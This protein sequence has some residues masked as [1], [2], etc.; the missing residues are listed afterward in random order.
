MAKAG[1]TLIEVVVTMLI[2]GIMASIAGLG[3]LSGVRG[4]VFAKNNSAI[5]EKAQLAMSRMNRSFLEILDISAIGTS[6][7][8][9]TYNRLIDGESVQ[10]TLYVSTS[11]NTIKI[12]AGGNPSGGDTLIDN[13][14]SL[15][16]IYKYGTSAW[17]V[18]DDFDRLSTIEVNLVLTRPDGGSNVTFASVI[19]PRNNANRGGSTSTAVPPSTTSCFVATAAFG[20]P[21]HP[22]VIALKDFRDRCLITWPGGK[23]VVRAYYK[24]GPYMAELIRGHYWACVL[25]QIFLLPIAGTALL[26]IYIPQILPLIILL[27]FTITVLISKLVRN[28]K[29]FFRPSGQK[30]SILLGLI[31]TIV[32][33]AVL[34]AALVSITSSSSISQISGIASTRAYYLAE[35]GMRYAGSEFRNA[36][37]ETAK[38]DKLT[39]LHN[40]NYNFSGGDG[41]FHLE[42]YPFYFKTVG[43]TNGNTLNAKFPGGVPSDMTIPP[44]NGYLKIGSDSSPRQYSSRSLSGS[45]ITFTMY[46][47][48]SAAADTNVLP[49]GVASANPSLMMGGSVTLLSGHTLFPPVNGTFTIGTASSTTGATTT[50]YSYKRRNNNVLE[51]VRLSQSP[52]TSFNVAVPANA[53]ITSMKFVNLQSRGTYAKGTSMEASRTISYSIPIGWISA[54]GPSTEKAKFQDTF[55]NASD[56]SNYWFTGVGSFQVDGGVLKVT[57]SGSEL[58]HNGGFLGWWDSYYRTSLLTL[59][60]AAAGVDL[61]QSW[62]SSGYLLSYDAQV[63]IKNDYTGLFYSCMAG[64]I[65]RV[66]TTGQSYGVSFLRP[67]S[68]D[69]I[70]GSGFFYPSSMSNTPMIV[71][72]QA[73]IV[74][75][76]DDVPVFDVKWLAYKSLNGT[77]SGV[78]NSSKKLIPWSTLLVRVIEAVSMEFSQGSDEIKY[79]DTITG[80]I[81]GATAFVNG[82]PILDDN[83]SWG[84]NATGWLTVSSTSGNFQSSG[85]DLKV[86]GIVKAHYT[87]NN[88]TKD[89][90]IRVYYGTNA[91][92]GS[93]VN[94]VSITDNNRL[95]HPVVTGANE[96]KWP[97]DNLADLNATTNDFFT[98]VQ[99]DAVNTGAGGDIVRLGGSSSNEANAII[100]TNLLV[101]P[102]TGTFNRSEVGLD[103]WGTSNTSTQFDDFGLQ[104]P[105]PGQTQGFLPGIQQ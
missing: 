20:N 56:L 93:V 72:W 104:A 32:I 57:S 10:E 90:Y 43:V 55:S 101:T 96:V 29:T 16:L 38:D 22:V 17:V 14:N 54:S 61:N 53:Y 81:S 69:S 85:E 75:Y 13:V 30:G 78:F 65:F 11:D 99:W 100:R 98:L 64:L 59:N 42:I 62:M 84:S 51:G 46:D 89:N 5:S 95:A 71:L 91:S 44:A 9:V 79:G 66:D 6:P 1:F 68:L 3:I 94:P 34:G 36:S 80:A 58:I 50:V 37:G 15:S 40:T 74:D 83:K 23:V 88:R 77:S 105:V 63:K 103:T 31:A 97:P 39:S 52:T 41:T 82:T 47:S 24:V 86:N 19:S 76:N 25:T 26:I 27:A 28:E 70:P 67:N 4:Y 8:R 7:T 2:V 87:G 35:G 21:D 18:G 102:N 49:V 48:I 33:F 45:N 60:W 92:N 73:V 12:A